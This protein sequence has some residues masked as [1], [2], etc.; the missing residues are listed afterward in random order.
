MCLYLNR[1][2]QIK[3]CRFLIDTNIM[4]SHNY[5]DIT[6]TNNIVMYVHLHL[7]VFVCVRLSSSY[8]VYMI[9]CDACVKVML[10]I[11]QLVC[12]TTIRLLHLIWPQCVPSLN[13]DVVTSPLR[14]SNNTHYPSFYK[15]WL[16]SS[17]VCLSFSL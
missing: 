16:Y 12:L 14:P 15:H 8:I 1:I 6:V 9:T 10:T 17:L 5:I 11:C 3:I 13:L 4:C 2:C 7:T